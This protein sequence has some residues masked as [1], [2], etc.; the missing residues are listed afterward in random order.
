M[1]IPKSPGIDHHLAVMGASR[2]HYN[3]AAEAY[4]ISQKAYLDA[5]PKGVSNARRQVLRDEYLIREEVYLD[6][7]EAVW[8]T[9]APARS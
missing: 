8:R 9:I 5:L 6:A 2:E 4:L 3:R 1:P 7:L